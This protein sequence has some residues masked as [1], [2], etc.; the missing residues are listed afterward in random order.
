[1]VELVEV[2]P[3]KWRVKRPVYEPAR[4]SFSC[5]HVISDS[6]PPLEQVDGNFY[7]SKRA[8]RAVGRAHGMIEIGTEKLKPKPRLT[9]NDPS[10]AKARRES[11]A[12][13]I[14]RIKG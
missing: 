8:F 9:P 7:T 13:A 1:M 14:Q 12:K 2:A 11:I 3:N 4:S 5:P 10:V 6:M